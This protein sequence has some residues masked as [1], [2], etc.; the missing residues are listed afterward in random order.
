M[1]VDN[2]LINV[3]AKPFDY[4]LCRIPFPKPPLSEGGFLF[5]MGSIPKKSRDRGQNQ[6]PIDKP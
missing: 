4:G 3:R 6:F 5:E 1:T 2:M